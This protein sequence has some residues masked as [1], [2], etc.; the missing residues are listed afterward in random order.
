MKNINIP[1]TLT[2]LRIILL[3][4]MF[5]VGLDDPFKGALIAAVLG[6]TDFIDGYIA[7]RFNQV[8]A[9]GRIL[10]PISDRLLLITSF[11]LFFM[12]RSVPNWFLI[13]IG[14]RELLVGVGTLLIFIRKIPRPDVNKVGKISAVVNTHYGIVE[15][16]FL[17]L[18]IFATC[19]SIPTGYISLYEYLS[20]LRPKTKQ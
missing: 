18:A 19:V 6:I 13:V 8:T 10:D 15:K 12:T 16:V 20:V 14:L 3:V 9:L 1:N 2:V 5:I 11:I 7:R 17:A 4:P